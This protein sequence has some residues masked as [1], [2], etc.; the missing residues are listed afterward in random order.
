MANRKHLAR[1]KQGVVPWN[2]WRE[3][4]PAIKAHLARAY[5]LR[6]TSPGRTSPGQTSPGR[7]SSRRAS[8]GRTSPRRTSPELIPHGRCSGTST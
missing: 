8:P 1:L 3:A 5:L 4:H 2:Q 7:T 6:Q